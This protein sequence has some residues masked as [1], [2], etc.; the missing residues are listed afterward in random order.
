MH[1]SVLI[2]D[3]A[4]VLCIA[5]I[6]TI[7]FQKIKQPTVL[8]YLIA[9][10]II[11]PYTPPFSLIDDETEIRLLAELGVIFLMFSLGLEFTFNKLRRLGLPALII[12]FFEVLLMVLIGFSAG[13]FLGWSHY[14]SLLLGAAL[15]IS[16]TTIIVKA[17]EEYNLKPLGFAE[18]MVGVLLI[19]DLLAILLL[20]FVSASS[21][22]PSSYSSNQLLFTSLELLLVI[23]SWFLLGYFFLPYIMRKIQN[24][25]N[26]ETLTIISVGL[27]L[28]LSSVAVYFHYSA[29]LGA[30]IMGTILAET[31]LS[32]KIEKLTLPI[33]DI[34]AAVF[35]VSVGMLID[36]MAIVHDKYWILFLALLTIVGKILT[37]GVGALLA[38]Q[39]LADSLRIGF[40]MAQI[41][42]FSFIIIGI[43]SSLSPTNASLYPIIVAI[44][45]ITTFATPYLM[46]LG[47]KL[48]EKAEQALPPQWSQGLKKY[49]NWI[50]PPSRESL[51]E[52]SWKGTKVLRFIVNGIIIAIIATVC[53][54]LVIPRFLPAVNQE[55]PFQFLFWLAILL[56]ASPFIWAMLFS[57]DVLG[58]KQ[59]NFMQVLVWTITGAELL[60]LGIS[61]LTFP[62]LI[63]PLAC[64]L[65]VI[66][67]LCFH[68]IK[69]SYTWLETSLL[70]NLTRKQEIDAKVLKRLAP[71]ESELVRVKVASH[72]PFIG[73]SLEESQLRPLFGINIVAIR[74]ELKTVWLPKAKERIFPEDELIIL[75]E[76]AAIDHFLDYNHRA[77]GE[78]I[79]QD[80]PEIKSFLIEEHHPLI[81]QSLA[82]PI[83][84]EYLPGLIVGLERQKKQILNPPSTTILQEGDLVWYISEKD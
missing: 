51:Q 71:W 58:Q 35:F 12:G 66:F 61:Y 68:F 47:M 21:G 70:Y 53:A 25:I 44:S 29:A 36:P 20:V 34:F 60:F 27:C 26:H 46:K 37:S 31:P 8:G 56:L 45:A 54:H 83:V 2:E 75:G 57:Y 5:G 33:R 55:W 32:Y 48:S 30:F 6:V 72:F 82:N 79:T 38:G 14:D 15:S 43:G 50:Q 3:L 84:R 81:N 74:R 63:V 11:G 73:Q 23:T 17:L 69:K 78:Q 28:F 64:I 4:V 22:T 49:Q 7:L 16:S 65:F 24:Y 52:K 1:Q 10:I 62:L 18:L 80:Q 39:T 77:K 13:I 19:E 42:E 41:G 67:K 9:G 59:N 76:K 40:S